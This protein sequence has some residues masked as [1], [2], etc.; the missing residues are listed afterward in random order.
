M[1]KA[2]SILLVFALFFA[3][4]G[5]VS[6][7]ATAPKSSE[8]TVT[9]GSGAVLDIPENSASA[10]IASVYAVSVPFIVALGL[11]DRVKARSAWAWV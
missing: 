11:S 3:L 9:D 1:K 2:V 10:T 6:Q 5:C 7:T 4:C 8:Q